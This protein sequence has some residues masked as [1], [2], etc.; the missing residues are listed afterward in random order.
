[1]GKKKIFDK[2]APF[3]VTS[4]YGVPQFLGRPFMTSAGV[5]TSAIS[6]GTVA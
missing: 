5:C 1:M 4:E 6:D 2:I 3:L